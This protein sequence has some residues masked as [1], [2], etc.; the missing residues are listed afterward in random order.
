MSLSAELTKLLHVIANIIFCSIPE[1]I[2]LVMFPLIL[3]GQFDFL[4]SKTDGENRFKRI[5]IFRVGFIVLFIAILSNIMKFYLAMDPT[6]GSFMLMFL[7]FLLIVIVY[8][9]YYSVKE[10]LKAFIFSVITFII[11]LVTEMLYIPIVLSSIDKTIKEINDSI[12]MNFTIALPARMIHFSII[13]YLLK[14][15]VSFTKVKLFKAV[16]QSRTLIILSFIFLICNFILLAILGKLI[17]FDK[18]LVNY[19]LLTQV[20]VVVFILS[21]PLINIALFTCIIYHKQ[22]R[23]N[24][25]R[26]IIRQDLEATIKDMKRFA[27]SGKYDKINLLINDLETDVKRVYSEE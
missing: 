21:M 23:E 20:L 25:D 5:D 27:C 2:F 4:E 16:I 22:N 19:N 9:L 12:L 18:I 1:E 26:F 24:E 7:L 10:I 11:L 3:L 17:I 8:R 14:K 13:A 15:K 6:L